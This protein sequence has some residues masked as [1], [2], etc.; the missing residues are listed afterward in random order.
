MLVQVD[1]TAESASMEL[2]ASWEDR[3]GTERE[4]TTTLS[5]PTRPPEYF[6]NTGVR[7]AVLLSRYAD[8]LKTWLVAEQEPSLAPAEADGI[9]IP[10]EDPPLGEWEQQSQPLTVS[11]RNAD[12]IREFRAHFERE[13]DAVGD[14]AL[15]REAELLDTILETA[16]PSPSDPETDSEA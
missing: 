7:K 3:Q 10:A 16:E 6:E 9:E 4:T 14:D 5:F 11:E 1:R 2:R 8:L 12:R 13:A 15:D